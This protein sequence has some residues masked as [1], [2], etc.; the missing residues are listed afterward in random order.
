MSKGG[1]VT[2]ME[3]P[4]VRVTEIGTE[5]DEVL[6]NYQIRVLIELIDIH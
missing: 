2:I 5:P 4:E 3:V 6:S 1:V